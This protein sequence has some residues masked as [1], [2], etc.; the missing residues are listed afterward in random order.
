LEFKKYDLTQ[1][2]ALFI[3]NS[4]SYSQFLY[5]SLVNKMHPIKNLSIKKIR[6]YF[7]IYIQKKKENWIYRLLF[8]LFS[9]F[10][11]GITSFIFFK[12]TN[13]AYELYLGDSLFVKRFVLSSCSLLGYFSLAIA[14]LGSV[15]KFIIN[16]E[17]E[18]LNFI[19]DQLE[20]DFKHSL[21]EGKLTLSPLQIF[22]YISAPF[23]AIRFTN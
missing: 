4:L 2:R 12:T 16:P 8:S 1:H 22:Q 9:F 17:K 10:F 14:Y 15:F 5:R 13:F 3:S 18:A 11:F 20:N 6:Y 23:Q 19:A 7:E 21:E